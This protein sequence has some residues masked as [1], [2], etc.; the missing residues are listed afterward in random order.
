M[1]GVRALLAL[2]V[3]LGLGWQRDWSWQLMPVLL[4]VVA[5][6]LTKADPAQLDAARAELARLQQG[7]PAS[8]AL[9]TEIV[10]VSNAACQRI[11]DQFGLKTDVILG[12]SFYRDKVDRVYQELT[13]AGLAETSEGAL[14]VFHPEHPRFRTQPFLIRKA[15]GAIEEGSPEALGVL[16]VASE[17]D[18]DTLE[19]DVGLGN[20]TG[21]T[22][23]ANILA[24]RRG[25]D[26]RSDTSGSCGSGPHRRLGMCQSCHHRSPS[27]TNPNQV[28][29]EAFPKRLPARV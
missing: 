23:T 9:W 7:D 18:G 17:V 12:E 27:L 29:F 3:V 16:R 2:S 25:A 21:R 13:Q 19:H 4:G 8:L 10:A 11:Y 22:A 15:D 26:G 20:Q 5:S 28:D 24:Y 1:H 14:V 6:A